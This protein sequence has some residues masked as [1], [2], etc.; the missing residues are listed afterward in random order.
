[1]ASAF[2]SSAPARPHLAGVVAAHVAKPVI[3]VPIDSSA[4]NGLDA[5][6]STVQMPPGIGGDGFNREAGPQMP[7]CW[8]RRSGLGDKALTRAWKASVHSGQVEEA[9]QKLSS[10]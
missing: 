5:L 4:L 2:S 8:P 7:A 6:L 9:A 1:V 3:G 10:S